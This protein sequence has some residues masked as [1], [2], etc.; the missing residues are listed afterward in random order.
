MSQN[1]PGYTRLY[2]A[3]SSQATR[4]RIVMAAFKMA[5]DVSNESTDNNPNWLQR[6]ELAKAVLRHPFGFEKE[7]VLRVIRNAT[8]AASAQDDGSLACTDSDIEFVIA[9]NWTMLCGEL[10]YIVPT[11]NENGL[12]SDGNSRLI[13]PITGAIYT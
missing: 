7:F 1:L 5:F 4:G 13:D 12:I 8:I 9:G 11:N 3:Y 2:L 6:R 10:G